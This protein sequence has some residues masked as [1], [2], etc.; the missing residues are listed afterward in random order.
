V[1]IAAAAIARLRARA[2][3]DLAELRVH[4]HR[5]DILVIVVAFVLILAAGRIH[6]RL[7]T[8]PVQ[9][10][11]DHGLHFERS[12]AWLKPEVLP[13][14]APR[15][16]RD[17]GGGPIA[18]DPA[19]YYVAYTSSLDAKARIEVL[20]DK[21]PAWSNIVTGLELDRRTRWGELYK[22]DD[23]KVLSI[24]GHDWLR[25]AYQYSY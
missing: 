7:V 24:A 8:P 15:L 9:A 17:A 11:D 10:F 18:K 20:I 4:Y 3:T 19:L 14:P 21:K 13:P 2:R 12:A 22:L 1:A 25:T 6:A 16:V 5:H 23:S